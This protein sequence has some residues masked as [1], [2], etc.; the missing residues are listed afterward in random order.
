MLFFYPEDKDAQNLYLFLAIGMIGSI[1]VVI[2]LMQEIV[3][4]EKALRVT[5]LANQNQKN[6][7][8]AYADGNKEYEQ[9]QKKCMTIKIS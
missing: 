7:L 8:A 5:T 6:Q 9:Q 4:K 2:H 1:L 3:E